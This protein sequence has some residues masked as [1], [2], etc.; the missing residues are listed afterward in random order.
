MV[1]QFVPP[2]DTPQLILSMINIVAGNLVKMN[3]RKCVPEGWDE[4]SMRAFRTTVQVHVLRWSF[5]WILNNHESGVTVFESEPNIGPGP[6][7]PNSIW[8]TV[9]DVCL[10]HGIFIP[11][12]IFHFQIEDIR[13]VK[14]LYPSESI[15]AFLIFTKV[16]SL[17]NLSSQSMLVVI[18]HSLTS[19]AC[20]MHW[21]IYIMVAWF[22]CNMVYWCFNGGQPFICTTIF[23]QQEPGVST[24]IAR[25]YSPTWVW[26]F[27]RWEHVHELLM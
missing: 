3:A 5:P 18:S 13:S 4:L 25:A 20:S 11:C 6:S 27:F 9:W 8:L 7:S 24:G 23:L 17:I 26:P 19:S 21:R 12:Q 2:C 22:G 15:V 16:V 14:E 1:V 10:K